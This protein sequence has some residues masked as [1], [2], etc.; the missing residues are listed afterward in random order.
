MTAPQGKGSWVI[1]SN[2]KQQIC[3]PPLPD[4]GQGG[5]S[6]SPGLSSL[7]PVSLSHCLRV[8]ERDQLFGLCGH[9]VETLGCLAQRKF[10]G[11]K[12]ATDALGDP[13]RAAVVWSLG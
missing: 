11:L 12:G 5:G 9:G 10:W 7:E 1:P 3:L 2:L 8:G 4:P 13:P 6:G